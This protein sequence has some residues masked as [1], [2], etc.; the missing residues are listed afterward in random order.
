M[1]HN[2]INVDFMLYS[3]VS[4]EQPIQLVIEIRPKRYPVPGYRSDFK[5]GAVM[6]SAPPPPIHK[7]WWLRMAAEIGQTFIIPLCEK[8]VVYAARKNSSKFGYK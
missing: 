1:L 5:I 7:V 2:I 4:V 8:K 3:P 6:R